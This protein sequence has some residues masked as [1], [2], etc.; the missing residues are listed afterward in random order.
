MQ[1]IIICEDK[2]YLTVIQEGKKDE[3]TVK[4]VKYGSNHRND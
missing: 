4:G 3:A 2:F 1:S